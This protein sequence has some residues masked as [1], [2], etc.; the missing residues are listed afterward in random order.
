MGIQS[1]MSGY[2][3]DRSFLDFQS[4]SLVKCAAEFRVDNKLVEWEELIS[5]DT[6]L[7]EIDAILWKKSCWLCRTP[8]EIRAELLGMQGR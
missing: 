1:K 7:T 8:Q 2:P 6:L 5:S 3:H 4:E